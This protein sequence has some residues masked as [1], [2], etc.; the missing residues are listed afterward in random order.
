MMTDY[1]DS[2]K[3]IS[4]GQVYSFIFFFSP[5]TSKRAA[6]IFTCPK[7]RLILHIPPLL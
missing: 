1:E 7:E 3:D 5:D 6:T 2:D 4:H